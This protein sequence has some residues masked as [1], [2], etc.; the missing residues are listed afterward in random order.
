M[1]DEVIR[2][3]LIEKKRRQKRIKAVIGATLLEI[4]LSALALGMLIA[5][6]A[7]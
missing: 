6:A 2:G 1:N 7:S 3:I 5:I 4:M